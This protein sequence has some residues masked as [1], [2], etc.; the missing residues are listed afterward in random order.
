[1]LSF[2]R[3]SRLPEIHDHVD[4]NRVLLDE[5]RALEPFRQDEAAER[6]AGLWHCFIEVF[7]SPAK[8]GGEPKT[9]QDNYIGKF[10]RVAARS[11]HVKHTEQGH[12]HYSVALM[13]R[14][15]V[16]A[17][18]NDRQRSALDLSERIASLINGVRD[19]QMETTT[20]AIVETLALSL[21][22][23]EPTESSGVMVDH[24]LSFHEATE[25]AN[26][27]DGGQVTSVGSADS[28][29]RA[30]IIHMRDGEGWLR[31]RLHAALLKW[32]SAELDG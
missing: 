9:V 29:A 12:L 17:R 14:F 16:A 1:M 23:S 15:L 18:D 32:R 5:F 27:D 19:R 6:L 2:R 28:P 25:T 7:G 13:L 22:V 24:S 11:C 20:N 31:R 21:D 26:A 8:F 10:E 4:E 30:T 3:Q